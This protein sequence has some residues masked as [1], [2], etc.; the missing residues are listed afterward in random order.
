MHELWVALG[1]VLVIEGTLYA[2]FP[3]KMVEIARQ[4]PEI[5]LSSLRAAGLLILILGWLTVWLL[6][7]S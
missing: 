1:L 4:L 7:S 6:K 5:P 3:R 2:L